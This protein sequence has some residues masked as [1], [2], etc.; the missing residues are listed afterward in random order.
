[1]SNKLRKLPRRGVAL[2]LAILL[3]LSPGPVSASTYHWSSWHG[4]S[5]GCEWRGY[6]AYDEIGEGYVMGV[7]YARG[8]CAQVKVKV[9]F[10]GGSIRDFGR[11]VAAAS[12]NSWDMDFEASDHYAQLVGPPNWHR[13]RMW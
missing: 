4:P 13:F 7:T 6:H 11:T 8:N 2:L 12:A 5:D 10:D 1:M 9:Y 3:A